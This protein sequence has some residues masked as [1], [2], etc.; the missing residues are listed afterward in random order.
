ML[1]KEPWLAHRGITGNWPCFGRPTTVHADNGLAFRSN[2]LHRVCGEYHI[3]L[4]FRPLKT[5]QYGGHIEAFNK[6]L[7]RKIHE[8]PGSTFFDVQHR[9]EYPSE[10]RASLTLEK[11]EKWLCEAVLEYH[12]EF[13]E[14]IQASPLSRY[15]EAFVIQKDALPIAA[16]EKF[17]DEKQLRIDFMPFVEQTV[18]QYGVQL[19]KVRYSHSILRPFVNSKIPG[20]YA[21][22][23]TFRFHYDPRDVSHIFFYH[24]DLKQYFPIPYQN[25][26]N[27]KMSVWECT[28]ANKELRKA[29]LEKIDEIAIV[30][31]VRNRREIEAAAAKQ[32]RSARR[33][34]A[35]VQSAERVPALSVVESSVTLLRQAEE[36]SDSRRVMR[37]YIVEDF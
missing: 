19:W 26:S 34:A 12:E 3:G 30:K 18:Q 28:H 6:T 14:G 8:I 29:G 23:R 27:P 1:P 37:P 25:I 32:S 35:R 11:F 7:A 21:T 33:N 4:T 5:P 15:N 17:T 2:M 13:H 16:P 31:H 20:R 9:G 24:P 36:Q 10:D 22:K